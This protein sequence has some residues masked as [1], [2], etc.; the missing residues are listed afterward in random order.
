ME[1]ESPTL[2]IKLLERLSF[3][4]ISHITLMFALLLWTSKCQPEYVQNT[5][6]GISVSVMQFLVNS[7]FY[8]WI[9]ELLSKVNSF[10]YAYNVLHI[11][12]WSV[13]LKV[14]YFSSIKSYTDIDLTC[15]LFASF[16]ADAFI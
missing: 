1:G 6:Q 8:T 15:S 16:E 14:S 12:K 11:T 2:T 3:K 9:H 5:G 13:Y 4:Q 10:T 7:L